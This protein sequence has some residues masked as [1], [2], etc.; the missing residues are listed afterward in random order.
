MR[1]NR[2][3]VKT[4]E[5][6]LAHINPVLLYQT[7]GDPSPSFLGE[8]PVNKLLGLYPNN[9]SGGRAGGGEGRGTV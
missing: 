8:F 4:K 9:V 6:A 2:K 1:R 3:S 7:T 5:L